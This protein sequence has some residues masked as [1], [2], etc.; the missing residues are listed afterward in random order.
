MGWQMCDL[1]CTDA[2]RGLKGCLGIPFGMIW[3]VPWMDGTWN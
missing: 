3:Y 1:E 2:K